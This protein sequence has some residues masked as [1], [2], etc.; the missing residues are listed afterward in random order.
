MVEQFDVIVIGSG[1][2]GDPLARECANR[3]KKTALIE[4]EHIGGTCINTGCTPTKTMIA[5]GRVAYLAKRAAEYGITTGPI[6]TNMEAVRARKRAMVDEFRSSSEKK[7]Y[8]T[9]NLEVICESASFT[10]PKTLKAGERE[11]TAETIVIDTGSAPFIPPIKGLDQVPYLDN[12]SIMELDEVPFHL[13]I[14]GGSYISVEFA[15][16]F[17]RLGSEVTIVEKAPHLVAREDED[18]SEALEKVFTED[19]ITFH[20]KVSAIEVTGEAGNL[21]VVLDNG[22]KL[23]ASHLLVALGRRPNTV[24]LKLKVPGIETL[25]NGAVKVDEFLE[26][27][28]KGVYAIGD[29]NGG[30]QFTHISYDDFRILR[31]TLLDGKKASTKGRLVPYVVFTDPQLGHVGVSEKEAKAQKI[32]YKLF[33]MPMEDV[34]RAYEI[35]E[36]RGFMKVLVDPNSKVIIGAAVLGYEGGEIMNMLQ[37]A[38]MGKLPYPVLKEGIFSHPTLAEGF[39]NLFDE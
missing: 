15:Q 18:V 3:G 6:S 23:S 2:G 8:S 20:L 22:E 31:S 37:I 13:I 14:L 21:Q 17:R 39:N 36:S 28:V 26:T 11:L 30:P 27:N 4:R 35:G 7:D 24:D 1:Q 29:V 34:A 25:P 38:L 33:S 19:G 5:S 9:P 12:A 16:L 10:G 32:P